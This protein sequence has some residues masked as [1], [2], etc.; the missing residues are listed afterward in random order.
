MTRLS[1]Y[2]T[3][4]EN[5]RLRRSNGVLEVMLHTGGETLVWNDVA[6]RELPRLFADIGADPD[7]HVVILTGTGAAFCERVDVQSF[8]RRISANGWDAIYWEGLSLLQHLLAI[9]VPVIGAVNGPARVHAELVVMSDIV[10]AS[11]DA[12]FQDA[13]HYLHGIVPGDGVHVAWP[14]L[15]GENR[16]RYFLLTGQELTAEEA[17]QLGVVAEVL[18]GN[19]LLGRARELARFLASKPAMARRYTRTLLTRRLRRELE[20]DL[21]HGLALEGMAALSRQETA[22]AG[23]ARVANRNDEGPG[24]AT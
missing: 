13:A 4:Y 6:H 21:G 3:R 16:G 11:I 23:R 1:D 2:R 12:L 10:L 22:E 14:V 24:G 5:A 7:N 19:E 8:G 15:L 17:K 20:A 9:P 18:P